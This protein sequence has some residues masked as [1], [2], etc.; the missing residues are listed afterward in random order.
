MI[1]FLMTQQLLLETVM[2]PIAIVDPVSRFMSNIAAM[3]GYHTF[4]LIIMLAPLCIY[5]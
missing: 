5:L 2:L 1:P 3:V 4:P